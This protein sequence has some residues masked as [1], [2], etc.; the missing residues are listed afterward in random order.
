MGLGAGKSINHQK[1]QRKEMLKD[2][3]QDVKQF[4]TDFAQH[5]EIA[6]AFDDSASAVSGISGMSKD[7]KI[8]SELNSAFT[9]S[10]H[11]TKAEM[12]LWQ[13]K[14]NRLQPKT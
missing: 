11:K 7:S 9:S 2:I 3:E 12:I 6:N 4:M 5:K 14:Q 1:K 10:A 13:R 8:L